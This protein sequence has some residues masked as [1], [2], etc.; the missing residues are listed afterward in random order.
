MD[1][2]N[3]FV[4]RTIVHGLVS[5]VV[6]DVLQ[7]EEKDDLAGHGLPVGERNVPSLN[8]ELFRER[9]EKPDLG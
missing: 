3:V 1:F 7:E 6:P 9:V 5:E 4:E 2:V 8:T